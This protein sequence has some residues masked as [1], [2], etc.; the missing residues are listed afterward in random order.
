MNNDLFLAPNIRRVFIKIDPKFLTFD[1][2]AFYQ[3]S[4]ILPLE[5][6]PAFGFLMLSGDTFL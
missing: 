4:Q 5:D 3:I 1:G 2:E 6:C